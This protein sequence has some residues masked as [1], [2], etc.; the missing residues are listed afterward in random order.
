LWKDEQIAP[1]A[2]IVKFIHS[3]GAAAGIQLAHAGR[4][5][6]TN[7]PWSSAGRRYP[8]PRADGCPWRRA[9]S[10]FARAR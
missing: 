10:P 3:Q 6:S 5:A 2:R 4:K 1:L 8:L 7:V 9:L